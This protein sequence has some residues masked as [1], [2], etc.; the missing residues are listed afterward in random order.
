MAYLT[1]CPA[2]GE[3]VQDLGIHI[4]DKHSD[5]L[6]SFTSSRRT[7][8]LP[9]RQIKQ[10]IVEEPTETVRATSVGSAH[11]C[12]SCGVDAQIID[13]RKHGDYTLR[14][15]RCPSCG[16]RFSTYEIRLR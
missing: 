3:R 10:V 12:E 9:V 16:E 11:R 1:L 2:C 15:K 4:D 14:R 7:P 8:P 6:K 13:S 5:I